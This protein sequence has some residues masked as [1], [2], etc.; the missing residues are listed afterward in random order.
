M[1]SLPPSIS[2]CRSHGKKKEET[3]R[4][5]TTK[6]KSS[7][8]KSKARW[9]PSGQFTHRPPLLLILGSDIDHT[10]SDPPTFVAASQPEGGWTIYTTE[11]WPL[12]ERSGLRGSNGLPSMNS[13]CAPRTLVSYGPLAHLSFADFV[14]QSWVQG[15]CPPT[16]SSWQL[17]PHLALTFIC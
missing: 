2:T 6:L 11:P 13:G 1:L 5:L 17:S 4:R 3:K 14:P 9:A 16:F 12:L 15:E 7:K 10:H 8:A